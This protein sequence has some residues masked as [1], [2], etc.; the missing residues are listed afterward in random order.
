[1][2]SLL[3]VTLIAIVACSNFEEQ[4]LDVFQCLLKSESIKEQIPKVINSFKT[5]DVPT[6]I[7]TCF[8]A[9]LAVKD[10]VKECLTSKK[11]LRNL[12]ECVN[13]KY[14]DICNK[15]CVGMLYL[16]CKKDCYNA[17]CL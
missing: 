9:Y 8:S 17:W 13:K 7:S 1:M 10:D 11:P 3:I 12:Q 2:K 15:K 5:K 14:F 4:I 6:I 16:I